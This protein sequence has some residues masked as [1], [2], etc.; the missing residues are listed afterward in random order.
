MNRKLLAGILIVF[1][2]PLMAIGQTETYSVRIADFSS[3]KYDEFSPVYYNNGI[4]FCSNKNT[5]LISN[6]STPDNKGLFKL[7]FVEKS[8]GNDPGKVRLFSKYLT[9]RFNDGPASFSR[10]RDTI[11]YSRNLKVDGTISENSNPRNKLGIFTAV[12]EGEK[13]EKITDIRFNN[14]YFNITT[15]FISPDGKRLFFTSDNPAGHGGSDLYFCQWKGD[16]WDD[17]VN[18][19][20]EVNTSGNESYPFVNSEGALYFSSDGHP[21]LGGK[22]IFYTKQSGNKWLVPVHLDAP[23]NSKFDDFALIADSMMNNGYFSSKRGSTID[24]YS[25]KTNIHQ[26][27]YCEKERVNQYC[28]K[29]ADESKI[30]V[31]ERY[32][33]LV[34]NFGDGGKANGSSTQHCFAGPG[35]YNVRLDAVDKKTGEL[36]FTKLSYTLELSDFEQP[37]ITAASSSIAGTAMNLDGMSSH[38]PGSDI[39]TYTWYFGDGSRTTGEKA[40]HTFLQKG[41]YE[42]KL[43]LIVRDRKTGII[44]DECVSRP[45]NVFTDQLGKAAFDAKSVVAQTPSSVIDYEQAKISGIYSAEKELNQDLVFQLEV[46]SSKARLAMDNSTFAKIPKK[47]TLREIYLSEE[48]LYSYV[49]DEEVNLM[50]TYPSFNEIKKL[51]YT[52]ARVRTYELQDQPSKDLNN[53][54][55][56]F[57]VLSDVFFIKNDFKLSSTGTQFLDQILGFMVKYPALRLE[58]DNHTDNTGSPSASQLLSQ[59]RSEAMVNYLVQNGVNASRLVAKGFGGSRPIASNYFEVDR[60]QNNRIDFV[61][62]KD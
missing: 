26:L 46:L 50:S 14:E 56:V 33:Q 58:I 25:F 62:L 1:Y 60:K 31:D 37:V 51:G 12:L 6:Y 5:S 24:I 20:P 43:G 44:H 13:W 28:F 19:G 7:Y 18:L 11:Y 42:V 48:K 41:V 30:Q 39:L 4:V 36:F 3:N 53:F 38:F 9:T 52:N 57:G 55:R 47:Y 17:P 15:P 49:I 16:F 2:F 34:W 40:N 23:V 10:N 29:F 27:Y 35:K 8:T 21:G 32:L 45:V 22:D 61:I 59:K 54:K